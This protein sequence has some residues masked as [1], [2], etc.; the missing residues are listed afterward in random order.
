MEMGTKI[1]EALCYINP[2]HSGLVVTEVIAQLP[3]KE[4]GFL[5]RLLQVVG[6]SSIFIYSLAIVQLFV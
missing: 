5:G 4:N 6:Q 3:G 2:G 1:R